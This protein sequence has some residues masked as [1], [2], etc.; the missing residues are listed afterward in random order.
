MIRYSKRFFPP[1]NPGFTWDTKN[2]LVAP[3]AI[4]TPDDE[5]KADFS[6]KVTKS[7][8]EHKPIEKCAKFLGKCDGM[9]QHTCEGEIKQ[10]WVKYMLVD[11]PSLIEAINLV[12]PA[13]YD[14]LILCDVHLR[15][16]ACRCQIKMKKSIIKN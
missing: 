14:Y 3:P 11:Y 8:T 5:V 16:L 4:L 12:A 7:K 6:L 13:F 9:V 15:L 10:A 2:Q 1:E